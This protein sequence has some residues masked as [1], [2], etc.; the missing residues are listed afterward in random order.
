MQLSDTS[1][2]VMAPADR[3]STIRCLREVDAGRSRVSRYLS[4]AISYADDN[5]D[6][7]IVFDLQH[8][9]FATEARRCLLNVDGV[10]ATEIAAIAEAISRLRGVILGVTARDSITGSLRI[11]F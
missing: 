4:D 10:R 3:Q 2:G 7:I 5:A 1:F 11:D 8:V 9:I 6:L